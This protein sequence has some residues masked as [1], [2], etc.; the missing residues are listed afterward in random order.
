MTAWETLQWGVVGTSP[1]FRPQGG[2]EALGIA[3]FPPSPHFS[4]DSRHHSPTAQHRP[5]PRSAAPHEQRHALR[6]P[7]KPSSD[8]TANLPAPTRLPTPI[9]A[10]KPPTP[11]QRNATPTNNRTNP[12]SM[13]K[14]ENNFETV[15][16]YLAS[17]EIKAA[18][19]K[20]KSVSREEQDQN[21]VDIDVR[22]DSYDESCSHAINV[23][24][25]VFGLSCSTHTVCF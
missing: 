5:D 1:A 2:E 3:F 4:P 9:T 21:S 13:Q 25:F 14:I 7:A 16:P 11:P 18:Q 19:S 17:T 10:A 24:G 8:A 20:Q 6:R 15:S 23:F 22:R 12:Q